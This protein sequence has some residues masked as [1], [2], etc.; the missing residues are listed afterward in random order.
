MYYLLSEAQAKELEDDLNST[1][2]A[3]GPD[4][5]KSYLL[6]VVQILIDQYKDHRAASAVIQFVDHY[7]KLF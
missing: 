2:L 3:L 7:S 6:T 1:L 5:W 4:W